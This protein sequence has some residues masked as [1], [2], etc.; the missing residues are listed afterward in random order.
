MQ[1][2]ARKFSNTVNPLQAKSV[3]YYAPLLEYT[4]GFLFGS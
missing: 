4:P 2:D 3:I 1:L